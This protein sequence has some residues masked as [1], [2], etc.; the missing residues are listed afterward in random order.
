[1]KVKNHIQFT[2][3]FNYIYRINSHSMERK[4]N[5]QVPAPVVLDKPARLVIR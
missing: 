2:M 5:E 1:M 4:T 3:S